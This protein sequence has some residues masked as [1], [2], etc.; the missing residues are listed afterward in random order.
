MLQE[1][2]PYTKLVLVS[3][4]RILEFHGPVIMES[5]GK[6][7]EQVIFTF[8]EGEQNKNLATVGKGYRHL[9]AGKVDRHAI[10]LAFGGGV[11]GDLGGYLAATYLRGIRYIQL[12][13]TLMAMVDSSIGGKVGIDMPGAKNAIGTFYQPEGVI[14]STEILRS[15]DLREVRNGMAEVAKYGFLYDKRIL[16]GNWGLESLEDIRD[17]EWI[18]GRCAELKGQVVARDE[19]DTKGERAMLNYGHTFGH[20]LESSTGYRIFRHGEAVAVG[21][22]MAGRAAELAGIAKPGLLALHREILIPLL[23]GF[24]IKDKV[25]LKSV[26]NDMGRDKKRDASLRFVLLEDIN[27]PLLVDS[28]SSEVVESSIQDVLEGLKEN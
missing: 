13:T 19:L 3:H 22:M 24:S 10:L 12:P 8:P 9:L 28:L 25:D 6:E 21:M 17:L 4:P 5:L 18:I 2:S 11:V 20:A 16:E 7:R 1:L 14:S 23:R 27:R 15:L 26:M